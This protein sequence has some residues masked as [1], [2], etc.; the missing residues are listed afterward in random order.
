MSVSILQPANAADEPSSAENG[1]LEQARLHCMRLATRHYENFTV[2]TSLL[3]P[4]MRQHFANVYA[5]CREADDRADAAASPVES[6]TLLDEWESQL[7]ACYRGEA[8]HPVFVALADTVAAHHIPREPFSD[9]LTAFRQDQQTTQYETFEGLLGYCRHSANPVGRIV[10]HLGHC[11]SHQTLEWSDSI[12]TGLQLANFWQDVRRDYA[13]GRI[14]IPQDQLRRSRCEEQVLAASKATEE[15][16]RVLAFE[17]A[18]AQTYLEAGTPLADHVPAWLRPSIRMFVGGGL[19][20]LQAIRR[21]NYDVLSHR[22]VV[23]RFTKWRL[24]LKAWLASKTA[25]R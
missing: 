14:Y 5:Y 18:R 21:R 13:K 17:V 11:A 25:S 1:S 20:V 19:A 12:C 16:R 23:S 10:L 8:S 24:F 6:L 3:P 7:N 22:P 15:F 9:L 2:I 4:D